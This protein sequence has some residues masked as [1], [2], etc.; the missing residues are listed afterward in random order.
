MPVKI[1]ASTVLHAVLVLL[2]AIFL[3]FVALH[4]SPDRYVRDLLVA[5]S[6]LF[7]EQFSLTG[8]VG[9][10]VGYLASVLSGEWGYS[11][12]SGLPVFR[13]SLAH[14]ESSFWLFSGALLFAL[15]LGVW[16]GV[17]GG[18]AKERSL[19]SYLLD[20]F[21]LLG[22]SAPTFWIGI[23]VI[24]FVSWKYPHFLL[25]DNHWQTATLVS[26]FGLFSTIQLLGFWKGTADWLLYHLAPF[27]V[28]SFFV[29]SYTLR[30]VR[31]AL[32]GE[33]GASYIS[34][35]RAMGL[36]LSRI[37]FRRVARN[38]L[39][40]LF[41][42]SRIFAIQVT[43]SAFLVEAVFHTSGL[44]SWLVESVALSDYTVIQGALYTILFIAVLIRAVIS[45]VVSSRLFSVSS[46]HS[47][48]F[49]QGRII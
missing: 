6:R 17:M 39:L 48:R 28:L 19:R 24:G 23:L 20:F 46:T 21:S 38:A 3:F 31:A 44:G 37:L 13:E 36:P 2:G 22:V 43:S 40:K 35:L 42:N 12:Q 29:F 27:F 10:F 33:I 25:V 7:E 34:G 4:L 47:V 49:N 32:E 30:Q 14:L 1:L 45:F 11:L 9:N 18:V 16:L 5:P 26:R 41:V 8:F 15:P